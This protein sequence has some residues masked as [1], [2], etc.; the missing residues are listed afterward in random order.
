MNMYS[1]TY[2]LSSFKVRACFLFDPLFHSLLRYLQA[3][4]CNSE[5]RAGNNKELAA[6]FEEEKDKCTVCLEFV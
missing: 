5:G 6:E 4:Y 1:C 2:T 3:A